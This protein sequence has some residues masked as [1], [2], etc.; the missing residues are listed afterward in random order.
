MRCDLR[1]LVSGIPHTTS[2]GRLTQVRMFTC[3][4]G[5]EI[6]PAWSLDVERT[7]SLDHRKLG[8]PEM[9]VGGSTAPFLTR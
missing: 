5:T 7:R 1:K 8:M 3:D 4:A 6:P 9:A 2:A